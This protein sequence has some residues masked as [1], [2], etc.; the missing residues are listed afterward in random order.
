MVAIFSGEL[1]E[2]AD[3]AKSEDQLNVS[4]LSLLEVFF[5]LHRFFTSFV[6]FIV[7]V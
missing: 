7:V 2:V 5:G 3:E 1:R 4:W 6:L